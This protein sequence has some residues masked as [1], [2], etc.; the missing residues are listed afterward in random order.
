MHLT[1]LSVPDTTQNAFLGL[2]DLA[3]VEEC[4]PGKRETLSSILQRTPNQML[5]WPGFAPYLNALPW[6][7]TFLNSHF[8]DKYSE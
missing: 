7:H 6:G 4:Y 1:S 8:A 5:S 2:G 3:Q